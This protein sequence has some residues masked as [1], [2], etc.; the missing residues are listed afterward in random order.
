[1]KY[2]KQYLFL[3][4][5]GLLAFSCS[6]DLLEQKPLSFFAPENVFIDASGYEAGLVP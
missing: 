4:L 5:V 1:M 3:F 2:I 6:E